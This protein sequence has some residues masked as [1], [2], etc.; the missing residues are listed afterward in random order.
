MLPC[1]M[2]LPRCSADWWKSLDGWT[3]CPIQYLAPFFDKTSC[4]L[5]ALKHESHDGGCGSA[6]L[7]MSSV[8][9]SNDRNKQK[10]FVEV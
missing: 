7:G 3:A 10:D 1:S 6:T 9:R 2:A 5:G 8:N 4:T